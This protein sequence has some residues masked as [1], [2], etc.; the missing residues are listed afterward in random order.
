MNNWCIYK[1][2]VKTIYSNY[3]NF[4]TYY[5][6]DYHLILLNLFS[7]VNGSYEL[8]ESRGR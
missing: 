8:K 1:F 3:Y 2:W 7:R 6:V 4:E 5:M